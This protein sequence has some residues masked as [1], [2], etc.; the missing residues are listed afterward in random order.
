M[1][2]IVYLC[3]ASS[4][5]CIQSIPV[6]AV[7]VWATIALN[8]A[9]I[10]CGTNDGYIYV[11]SSD[12]VRQL[13][14]EALLEVYEEKLRT[15]S[16]PKTSIDSSHLSSKERLDRP[17]NK[18]GE[19]ILVQ[20]GKAVCAYQWDGQDWVKIGDVVDSD[21]SE[22]RKE[23]QGQLY[24][25]VFDVQVDDRGSNLKLPYNLSG[26]HYINYINAYICREPLYCCSTICSQE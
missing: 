18:P 8:N 9:D 19:H 23:Y 7:S 24:D 6:P 15:A 17:G 2:L 4:K 26:T 21:D 5:K 1:L 11:Y 22:P 20:Q 10:A 25:Y 16:V 13:F 12:P 14:D 3:L